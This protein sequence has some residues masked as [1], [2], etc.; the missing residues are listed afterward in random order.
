MGHFNQYRR[1]DHKKLR[2]IPLAPE[3]LY[4]EAR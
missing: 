4:V 3:P 1:A 2:L